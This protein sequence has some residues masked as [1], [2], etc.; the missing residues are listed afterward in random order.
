MASKIKL[1]NNIETEFSITHSD[2]DEAISITS[3]KLKNKLEEYVNVKDFGAVGDGITDDFDSIQSALNNYNSVFVPKGTYLISQELKLNSNN[4]IFGEGDLSVIKLSDSAAQDQN[5]ITTQGNTR[6]EATT[7]FTDNVTIK[8]LCVDGNKDRFTSWG[9]V[10]ST[11]GCGIGLVATRFSLVENVFA[12]NNVKHGIDIA[13]AIYSSVDAETYSSKK[14]Y[15][16]LVK[17]CRATN[18]GDDGITTHHCYSVTIENPF[19][20]DSGNFYT[21]GNSNGVEIDDGSTDVLVIGGKSL[22]CAR[23]IQIK[24]HEYSPAANNVRV[25]GYTAENCNQSFALRHDGYDSSGEPD[26]T[27][28]Y[29]VELIG[30]TSIVPRQKDSSTLTVRSLNIQGYKNV[31]IKDFTVIGLNDITPKISSTANAT[32][33]DSIAFFGNAR[34]ITVDGLRVKGFTEST[35]SIIQI[36]N[37]ASYISLINSSFIDCNNATPI[38]V[39]SG[40]VGIYINGVYANTTETPTPTEVIKFT[41]SPSGL[42]Y[43]IKNVVK[44]G[45]TNYYTL[46]D[47]AYTT[48]TDIVNLNNI[49]THKKIGIGIDTPLRSLHIASSGNDNNSW[50]R[51]ENTDSVIS[52]GEVYGGIEFYGN[53]TSSGASGVRATITGKTNGDTGQGVLVFATAPSGGT[54]TDRL[55][56][57]SGGDVCATANTQNLGTSSFR[58]NTVYS[59][60]AA[61]V[62]SD[63]RIKQYYDITDVEKQVALEL[64]ANMR[65]FKL[66][67]AIALKGD[68]ARYHFGTSAQTVKSIFE[69]Y[70]LDGFKYGLLCY[71]EWYELDG[72]KI[73]DTASLPEGVVKKDLYSIRYEELLS[74]IIGAI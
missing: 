39:D 27:T 58:W 5:V 37:S 59:V 34:N 42:D 43:T 50:I 54:L 68:K 55:T 3:S 53:D 69:K 66:L 33:T 15:N 17:N 20:Y 51:L 13:G 1:K 56:V 10:E 12:K 19:I 11:G 32:T 8:D 28:A 23:G 30:C 26:S 40:T 25:I 4:T 35:D 60:N 71:D 72:K 2:G 73:E 62:S 70:G 16:V 64:K 44:S 21:V 36:N 45:Y 31:N 63:D 7:T 48:N 52:S 46:N 14:S 67:D 6:V 61:N 24:A 18:F 9:G 57:Y 65:K 38:N 74:F 29:N 47:V 22:N 41:N 49:S